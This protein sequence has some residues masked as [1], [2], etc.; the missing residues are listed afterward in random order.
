MASTGWECLIEGL[1]SLFPGFLRRCS[2]L[3]SPV[4]IGAHVSCQCCCRY[5]IDVIAPSEELIRPNC[6]DAVIVRMRAGIH[7]VEP[8][9]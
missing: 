6:L 7:E 4:L 1:F 2:V 8:A 9:F 5:V 3:L